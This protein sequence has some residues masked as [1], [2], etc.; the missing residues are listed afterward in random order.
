[1]LPRML[2]SRQARPEYSQRYFSSMRES[3]LD[4]ASVLATRLPECNRGLF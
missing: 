3:R 2:W 1:M 4:A